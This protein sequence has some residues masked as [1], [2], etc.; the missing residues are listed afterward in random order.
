M[1]KKIITT[2]TGEKTPVSGQ[3][4]PKGGRTEITMTKGNKVP[5]TSKGA[6]KFTLVDQT[7]HKGGK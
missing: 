5:P 3:Y 2:K 1:T 4:A 6:T 7:K